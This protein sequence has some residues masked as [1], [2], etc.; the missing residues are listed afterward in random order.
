MNADPAWLSAISNR[1]R[2]RKIRPKSFLRVISLRS[3]SGCGGGLTCFHLLSC[4]S[5]NGAQNRLGESRQFK[6]STRSIEFSFEIE[7]MDNLADA[8]LYKGK[9]VISHGLQS[10]Y[11]GLFSVRLK[12]PQY[13]RQAGRATVPSCTRPRHSSFFLGFLI[14][15]RSARKR[16]TAPL[17][18]LEA[19]CKSHLEGSNP[20]TRWGCK[21]RHA[22]N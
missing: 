4:S 1:E 16:S 14:I 2:L 6:A 19:G 10:L 18:L 13:F 8:Q 12:L 21:S 17:V 11:Q 5:L 15:P 3:A 7:S 20:P 9:R 22:Q